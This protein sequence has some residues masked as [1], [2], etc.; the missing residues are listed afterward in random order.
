MKAFIRRYINRLTEGQIF[1]N[2]DLN[3]CGSR[4]SI[5]VV[6][7]DLVKEERIVRLTSGLYMKGDAT[8]TRPSNLEVAREK[9][10]AF[11]HQLIEEA[12]HPTTFAGIPTPG[13]NELT[14]YF[15]G[16]TTSFLYGD[17]R[18]ILKALSPRKFRTLKKQ[19]ELERTVTIPHGN[20]ELLKKFRD[21]L[22]QPGRVR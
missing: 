21:F 14:F 13:K 3:S 18:I 2:T 9:A 4:G 7:S 19:R 10:Q 17:T 5:D 15:T 8:T 20:A 12:D 22:S 16:N 11:G 1:K 6:L